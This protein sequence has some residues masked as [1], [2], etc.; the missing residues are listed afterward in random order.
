MGINTSCLSD[1]DYSHDNIVNNFSVSIDYDA[2]RTFG[3]IIISLLFNDKTNFKVCRYKR[4]KY[5]LFIDRF[6]V[7]S[8]INRYYLYDCQKKR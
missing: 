2:N 7:I 3:I 5:I 4:P 8:W 6:I 1:Y